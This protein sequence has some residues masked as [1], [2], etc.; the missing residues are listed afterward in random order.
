MSKSVIN[1]E[2]KFSLQQ[3]KPK[4]TIKLA[5]MNNLKI[6]ITILSVFAFSVLHAQKHQKIS[7]QLSNEI[8]FKG[9][10][11]DFTVWIFFT[12]KGDNI[13]EKMRHATQELNPRSLKR[14][15]KSIKRTALVSILDIPVMES[16]V[17]EVV[18]LLVKFRHK[19]KWLNAI[20]AEVSGVQL[21]KI[22]SF[23]FVE[24]I[25]VVRSRKYDKEIT[26]VSSEDN[27]SK[28]VNYN[29][30]YG[31]SL[32][33]L[34]QI[35]VPIVH[36]MG[37]SG[38]GIL[39]CV[40]DAGFNNLEHQAFGTM[41]ILDAYDFV[42]D[43]NNVDDEADMGTGNH[44][45]NTLS[46]IGGFFEG[47]LVGPAYGASYLL[48]KT[49]NTDSETQVEEDNWVAGAEWA[50]GLGAE[51]TS[52]SLGYIDYDDGSGYDASE[53]DGNTAIITIAADIMASLGVLVVNSAGNE[54]SGTTTIG[55]PADG[56]EVL[57]IGAVTSDGTR[58]SFSSVGP[59][60]DG[61]I[62][63]EVMAMGSGVVVASTSGNSYTTASGTSFSCPLAA[64]AAALLWEMVPSASNME[65]FE[66]LKMSA[67]NAST[68]NNEYGW[69]IIDVYAA[70][71]YLALPHILSEPLSDSE[72]FNGPYLVEAKVTSNYNLVVGSPI[73]HYRANTGSWVDIVMTDI[74]NDNF[75]AVIP[76]NGSPAVYDYY[77]SAENDNALVSLPENAPVAHFTFSV[78]PDTEAPQINHN[79]IAEYYQN[80][81]GQ[82]QVIA[83]LTDNIGIDVANS[84]VDWKIN[85]VLQSN[86]YFNNSTA[87]MYVASFLNSALSLGDLIEYRLIVQ[88]VSNAHN[89]TTFPVNGYQSFMITDRISFEQNQFSHNW[90]FT[91][92]SNW[93]VTTDESQEGSFSTISGDIDDSQKSTISIDFSCDVS[94]IVSF[95]KKVSSEE[96]YDYL[97]FYIN[98]ELQE[99][100]AGELSWTEE[101]YPVDAGFY[102]LKW[103][104]YKDGS[105]SNGSDAAWIDNITFPA[106]SSISVAELST[107]LISLFP[108]PTNESIFLNIGTDSTHNSISIYN[109][110]GRLIKQVDDYE[111]RSAIAI[112]DMSNG[113]YICKVETENG[114]NFIKFIV[115][116]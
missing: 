15:Q 49:E 10:D 104:Y 110:A 70:Y 97:K 115:A 36:D 71:E 99:E 57:A 3:T 102:T 51:I 31:A 17:N 85:G 13:N 30:D 114:V 72:D 1:Y 103:E 24:R 62:K 46:T 65:I 93:L 45:T 54:G 55:A 88:D 4:Q 38:N 19:S 66:A 106:N 84:F 53:L 9:A 89:T 109:Q 2:K 35:N 76:G 26:Q 33:Q 82:A 116:K 86:V 61:R 21:D 14:R 64:G 41:T 112:S 22:A 37:Y 34:E 91:G 105:L 80:L 58:S 83:E 92:D 16:Y 32:T 113:I 78:Y 40:L 95:H 67:S 108:N 77:I 73:M 23:D 96:N 79:T 90:I 7:Q 101:T 11:E 50:E 69:G 74:G 81:W 6:F 52:T 107:D 12:D 87:N 100:W 18:P 28:S 25:D 8:T 94:G 75:T 59:T 27:Y 39:I 43:D 60:G 47:E 44:G 48:A 63:P 20:S 42:N 98:D 68:P 56:N 29:L 5:S 111:N